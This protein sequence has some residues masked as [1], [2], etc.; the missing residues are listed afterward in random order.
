MKHNNKYI[1]LG[2]ILFS[3]FILFLISKKIYV[4]KS[5]AKNIPTAQVQKGEFTVKLSEIGKLKSEKTVPISNKVE[6]KIIKCVKDGTLVKPG[7]LLVKI[8]DTELQSK[9]KTSM[10]DY[11]S[12]LSNVENAKSEAVIY[13]LETQLN[14]D[15]LKAS[16]DF[17]KAQLSLKKENLKRYERLLAENLVTQQDFDKAKEEYRSQELKVLQ[18]S[19]ELET[20]KKKDITN[21]KQK[22]TKIKDAEIQANIRKE[23]V[24]EVNTKIKDTEIRSPTRGIA[25]LNMVWTG[26]DEQ[27]I[28]EGLQVYQANLMDISDL[29]KMQI[30]V[31]F[32]EMNIHLLKVG[33]NVNFFL[34]SFPDK[35]YHGR[36]KEISGT[37]ESMGGWMERLGQAKRYFEVIIDVMESD[38]V[39][40]KP[41]MT[42][43]VDVIIEKIKNAVSVPINCVFREGK[44]NFVY[45]K[46]RGSFEKIEVETGEKNDNF[47][48]IKK[49]LSGNETIALRNPS[50]SPEETGP[51]KETKKPPNNKN[52]K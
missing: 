31:K 16:L 25:V 45:V 27:K 14:I 47:I 19:L 42:A 46:K 40:L 10:L 24:E 51:A 38:P 34:E 28:Q 35:I 39:I 2:L 21:K 6:G 43:N 17:E 5:I 26:G 33:Q 18:S 3:I 23:Q 15:K 8:D 13:N 7:D 32:P 49:G 52:K 22:E 48:V 41:G 37:A 36:V 50:K 29:S 1:K 30:S 44:K 9:F 20:Q 4:Q 11:Q 12:A